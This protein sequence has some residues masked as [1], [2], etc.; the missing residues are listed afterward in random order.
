[1]LSDNEVNDW[2][3]DSSRHGDKTSEG[4]ATASDTR[5]RVFGATAQPADTSTHAEDRR[6]GASGHRDTSSNQ[7]PAS[8]TQPERSRRARVIAASV[9]DR[10][11]SATMSSS[12]QGS[13]QHLANTRAC[14]PRGQW[15]RVVPAADPS[16]IET[17]GEQDVG[18]VG[19]RCR[20]VADQLVRPRGGPVVHRTRHRHHL[21]RSLES[22]ARRG[23]RSTSLAALDHD[24]HLA[25]RRE[26]A[27]ALW[28]PELLGL[29]AG[30]PL[31]Q[32]QTLTGD[33]LPKVGVDPW[34]RGVESVG[35]HADS[36]PRFGT[37]GATVSG[38]IDALGQA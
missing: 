7:P 17:Q 18:G 34:I 8:R 29:R 32:Q 35:N 30:R 23:E 3:N 16:V 20:P 10:P 38:A 9:S 13:A 36:S 1:M 14:S 19:H 11:T 27:V 33:G 31:G 24:E 22:L 2:A 26:D 25:Q 15:A 28:E 37:Q 5:S 4:S 21:D 6:H 12:V